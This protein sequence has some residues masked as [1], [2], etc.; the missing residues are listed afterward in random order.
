MS[1]SL[2]VLVQAP[3]PSPNGTSKASM[4]TTRRS[5]APTT[6]LSHWNPIAV[7]HR[8]CS[9]DGWRESAKTTPISISASAGRP[10][11]G[12]SSTQVRVW[13][14]LIS[15]PGPNGNT[16]LDT[17]QDAMARTARCDEIL[18]SHLTVARCEYLL[19]L[20][21]PTA[22]KPIY[23]HLARHSP[24][25]STSNP[26]TSPASTGKANSGTSSSRIP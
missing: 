4:S 2:V 18:V 14:L 26:A 25:S 8:P 22:S 15:D 21:F 11:G 20:I 17:L 9:R 7:Y 12:R 16:S 19:P 6:E 1:S 10:K 23:I 5:P 3:R 13:S 24:S